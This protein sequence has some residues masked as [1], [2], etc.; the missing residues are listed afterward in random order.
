M[1]LEVNRSYQGPE[2]LAQEVVERK[3]LGHP[4]TLVDGIAEF[5]EIQYAKHCLERFGAIPHHNLDKA[6]LLGG[7]CLQRFGGNNFQSPLRMMFMG[8]AS[9]SFGGEEKYPLHRYKTKRLV[10]I[11]NV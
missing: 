7:L 11:C 10:P 8:R 3:G 5:S 9:K 2:L 1:A 6:M 4:D